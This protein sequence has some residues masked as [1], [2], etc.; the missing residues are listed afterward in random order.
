[1]LRSDYYAAL[2]GIRSVQQWLRKLAARGE[3]FDTW[4]GRRYYCEAPQVV[5]GRDGPEVTRSFEYKMLNTLIQGSAADHLKESA[6]ALFD[7][8]F[9]PI[10]F[11]HDELVVATKRKT[12]ARRIREVLESVGTW[13][14]PMRA[15]AKWGKTW[16]DAK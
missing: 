11:V 13:R 5:D 3:P 12:D 1:M 10:L 16:A 4:G 15:G 8:G 7:A 2:P 9:P 14:V 6:I